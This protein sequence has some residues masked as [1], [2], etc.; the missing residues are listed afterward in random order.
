MNMHM[1]GAMYAPSDGVT[2]MLMLNYFDKSMQHITYQGGT[3]TTQLGKFTGSSTGLGDSTFA[4][5]ISLRHSAGSKL[6][7][8]AGISLPTGSTGE[9]GQILTPMNMRP[10]VRLP[11][12]MQLGS[13]SFDPIVGLNYS[14][15][16]DKVSWGAQ[17]RSTFRTSDNDDGYQL[18]DEHR[19]TAW[20]SYLWSPPL[21]TSLRI[22]HID[23]GN[24]DGIDPLIML[25][26]QTADPDR[27]GGTRTD[28]ILGTN[29]AGSG[30]L[31]GWRLAIEYAV[32]VAQS[33]DGPQLE[34][35]SLWTLG[36]QR[37]F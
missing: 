30:N 36:L 13:G 29:L 35:D 12:P 8:V 32:P 21:S 33:L 7:L 17:W 9:K 10:T 28:L 3:G 6:H 14:A 15:N 19:L 16:G 26:V 27:Q 4:A 25:P 18:G 2:L 11:Y 5:L 37:A 34:T 20:L 23:R 24:I 22:E 1:L 31:H